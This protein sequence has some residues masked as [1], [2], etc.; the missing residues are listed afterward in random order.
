M[1]PILDHLG[2]YLCSNTNLL[3]SLGTVANDAGFEGISD[4]R[5]V[6]GGVM[7]PECKYSAVIRESLLRRV[8]LFFEVRIL[9]RGSW[10]SRASGLAH[11]IVDSRKL[12]LFFQRKS[13]KKTISNAH[14]R[15][16]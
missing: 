1:V 13:S 15:V 6:G 14:G 7:P 4:P 8:N 9:L 5:A 16:F 2:Q 12:S 10:L 11:L 3:Q